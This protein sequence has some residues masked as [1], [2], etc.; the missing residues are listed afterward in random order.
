MTKS[1]KNVVTDVNDS[2]DAL[3]QLISDL[4]DTWDERT[5]KWQESD[6]GEEAAAEIEMLQNY[7]DELQS[8]TQPDI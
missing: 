5:E 3:E 7:L 6:K 8:I 4:Q 1:Q 2:I